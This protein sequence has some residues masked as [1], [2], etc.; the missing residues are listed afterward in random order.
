MNLIVLFLVL[1]GGLFVVGLIAAIFEQ[2][3][4]HEV[5]ADDEDDDYLEDQTTIVVSQEVP[6]VF[7]T[8]SSKK[9]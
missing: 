7:D 6:S 5:A 3:K 4:M 2:H 8:F 1:L 9:R